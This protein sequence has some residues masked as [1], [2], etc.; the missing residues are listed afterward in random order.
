MVVGEFSPITKREGKKVVLGNLDHPSLHGLVPV[1]LM[2]KAHDDLL[3]V[4]LEHLDLGVAVAHGDLSDVPGRQPG[5]G[6]D[7]LHD[8]SLADLVRVAEVDLY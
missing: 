3:G 8:L 1:E 2:A 7:Q 5:V 6:L 4:L